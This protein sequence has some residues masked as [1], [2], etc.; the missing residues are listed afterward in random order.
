V[1][2]ALYGVIPTLSDPLIAEAECATRA[3]LF[4]LMGLVGILMFRKV[5]KT[6]DAFRVGQLRQLKL[7]A[8]LVFLLGF[9]PTLVANVVKMVV[10][11]ENAQPIMRKL[12]GATNPLDAAP[13]TIRGDFGLVM[14]ENVIHGSDSPESAEREIGIFFGA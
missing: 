9:L 5:A 14:D 3:L 8:L 1:S 11:G 10:A 6:G 12:M 13:G 2:K 7:E 4:L